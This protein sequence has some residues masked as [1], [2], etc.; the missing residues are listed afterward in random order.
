MVSM[1]TPSLNGVKSL[2]ESMLLDCHRAGIS[3]DVSIYISFSRTKLKRMTLLIRTKKVL[4]IGGFA[5]SP[6]LQHFLKEQLELH[7]NINSQ[8]IRLITLTERYR[9]L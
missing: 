3:V 4:L 8:K 6:A 7:R 5:A 1:F 9:S 2:M